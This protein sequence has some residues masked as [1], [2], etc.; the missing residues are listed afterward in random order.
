[1]GPHICRQNRNPHRI[2]GRAE[3]KHC[4]HHLSSDQSGRSS[5]LAAIRGQE[6]FGKVVPAKRISQCCET[7][8]LTESKKK[9]SA[10]PLTKEDSDKSLIEHQAFFIWPQDWEANMRATRNG[11]SA[12]TKLDS[13]YIILQRSLSWAPQIKVPRKCDLAGNAS[14]IDF[15]CCTDS[16]CLCPFIVYGHLGLPQA[17]MYETV[18][19]ILKSTL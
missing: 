18:P 9:D 19:S 15:S 2:S 17:P 3:V 6:A 14:G 12:N 4:L 10:V 7:S 16:L 13:R 11:E 8:V 5:H 1:M